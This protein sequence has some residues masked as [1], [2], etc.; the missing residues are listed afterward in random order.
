MPVAGTWLWAHCCTLQAL[1]D[2]A[3]PWE[4]NTTALWCPRFTLNLLC[5][6]MLMMLSSTID[7]VKP[8]G[9]TAK[10]CAAVMKAAFPAAS[11]VGGMTLCLVP[12]CLVVQCADHRV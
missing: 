2:I 12:I 4:M 8:G 3:Q 11:P 6:L 1:P 5:A 10:V 9:G 7:A